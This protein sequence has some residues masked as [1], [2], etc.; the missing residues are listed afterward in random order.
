[1]PKEL[2]TIDDHS[3]LADRH[4]GEV[5]AQDDKLEKGEV[6]SKESGGYQVS[7][8]AAL[9][10]SAAYRDV[11]ARDSPGVSGNFGRNTWALAE[12]VKV[13]NEYGGS[14]YRYNSVAASLAKDSSKKNLMRKIVFESGRMNRR[15]SSNVA[16]RVSGEGNVLRSKDMFTNQ[17]TAKP[18]KV[19]QKSDTQHIPFSREE[20]NCT[21]KAG[22][23]KW[24]SGLC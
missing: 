4:A 13:M 23:H 9:L 3:S 2:L 15:T 24:D 8:N 10:D 5:Q 11:S 20:G 6:P 17:N 19:V 22:N 16:A 21:W 7:S 12:D 18:A 14:S 1:M